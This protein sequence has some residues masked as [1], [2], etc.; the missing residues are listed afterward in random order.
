[1]QIT[2]KLLEIASN[3]FSKA[4]QLKDLYLVSLTEGFNL[5][6][7]IYESISNNLS[8]KINYKGISKKIRICLMKEK[9]CLGV[10]Q[11]TFSNQTQKIEIYLN[12]TK[13]I[14]KK[15]R[16]TI[17]CHITNNINN[18]KITDD[19][20]FKSSDKTSSNTSTL[21]IS[22][23]CMSHV[24]KKKIK[25][26]PINKI[27]KKINNY[28][29]IRN[30]SQNSLIEK[31]Q[32]NKL[33]I[34]IRQKNIYFHDKIN[35]DNS[36]LF[37]E[38]SKQRLSGNI[39][40]NSYFSENNRKINKKIFSPKVSTYSNPICQESL[41]SINSK[42]KNKNNSMIISNEKNSSYYKMYKISNEINADN[43]GERIEKYIMDK[44][45]EDELQNDIPLIYPQEKKKFLFNENFN[46]NKFE[47]LLND[48]LL[49]YNN[50]SLKNLNMNE[51]ELE[52][53]FLVEKIYELINEY[54][55]EYHSLLN[56][57][58]SFINNIKYYAYKYNNLLKLQNA[59]K[60]K[61]NKEILK[62]IKNENDNKSYKYYSN[63]IKKLNKELEILKNIN[64]GLL[65]KN[66][67]KESSKK[68]LKNILAIIVNKN[69]SAL[70]QKQITNLN[71]INVKININENKKFN[72][73]KQSPLNYL[74]KRKINNNIYHKNQ[75]D[76]KRTT[77]D[78]AYRKSKNSTSK[79]KKSFENNICKIKVKT[80]S[81]YS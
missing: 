73:N 81:I 51:I 25:S 80:R 32:N 49:L 48:F 38:R 13:N 1:M 22:S 6:I 79:D 75:N 19:K 61:M 55:K 65:N 70:N 31:Y 30:N 2:F 59:L 37:S 10:G 12:N 47:Q 39:S 72:Q 67:K 21:T 63:N 24:I 58:N 68:L 52:F 8:Y 5:N 45:I 50:D 9:I 11:I 23:S 28:N 4:Y 56:Q 20:S 71:K 14:S 41:R 53:H 78:S 60:G 43:I 42:K 62:N 27:T 57:N 77:L 18:K 76:N 15:I 36:T 66:I 29:Y 26:T 46:E 69:K 7:N 44:S 54:Y 3:I 34:G 17:L 64:L 35:N 40:L 74:N 16:L 33:N